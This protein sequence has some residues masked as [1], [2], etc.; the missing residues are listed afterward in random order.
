MSAQ[1][2]SRVVC[3]DTSRESGGVVDIGRVG[4]W[5]GQI[6]AIPT[7]Q[8]RDL[9]QELEGMGWPCLWRPEASG[10]DALV[11]AAHM[12]DATSILRIATGI[13]Q[14]HARHPHTTRAAQKTLH[15]AS[16]GRFLLGLGVSHAPF[17]EGSRKL[18]YRTPYSDMVA[19][20]EA[21]AEAPFTAVAADDDPPTVLAALGPK[22]LRLAASAAQGAHPYFSP[23]EHTAFARETMGAGPLLAPEQMVVLDTDRDRARALAIQHMSRYLRLPNYTNN[24][25]RHG[26]TEGD[27]AGPSQ[28]LV[29]AIVVCGDVEAVVARVRQHHDAG[30]DHVCIQVLT[31]RPTDL[32]MRAWREI[33]EAFA[34]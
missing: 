19:Y 7:V 23:V 15:E 31:D 24:L 26:F 34:L 3:A 11:S 4:I 9:V 29:D 25:L 16:G 32:P 2:T 27:L 6:D 20:L 14:I 30:A 5:T 8:V 18:E 13:A 10:R 1:T 17:I 21:M 28:R 22:M 33:A 12:L